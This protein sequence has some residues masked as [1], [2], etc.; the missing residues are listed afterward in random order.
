MQ[1]SYKRIEIEPR[2]SISLS[3]TFT[4]VKMLQQ[5]RKRTFSHWPLCTTP[6]SAQMIEAGFFYCNVGDRVICIY[7]NLICQQWAP[8]IDDPWEVHETLSPHCPYVKSKLI[9]PVPSSHVT[10]NKGSSNA[11]STNQLSTP[12]NL[13][14]LKNRGPNDKPMIKCPKMFRQQYAYAKQLYHKMQEATRTQQST[15]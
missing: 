12:K 11:A 10:V 7:C 1:N 13:D 5:A 9:D 15:F 6:S 14:P 4:E 3:N 2:D 8:H